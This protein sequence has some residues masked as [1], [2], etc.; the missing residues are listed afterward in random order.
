MDEIFRSCWSGFSYG[1]QYVV[2]V[3]AGLIIAYPM[4]EAE[5]QPL[6]VDFDRRVKLEFHG[7]RVTSDAGLLSSRGLDDVLGFPA[8]YS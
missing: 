5:Q 3:W 4:G 6:R 1:N 2:I 8:A 7:S